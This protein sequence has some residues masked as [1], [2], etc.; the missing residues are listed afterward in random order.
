MEALNINDRKLAKTF[1]YAFIYGASPTKLGSI[2]GVSPVQGKILKDQFLRNVPSLGALLSKVEDAASRGYIRGLDGRRL[3]VR[4]AHAA[5]NTL[6][7]G[8]GSIVCKQWSVNMD[9]SIRSEKLKANLVNTVHD[10]LQYESHMDDAERLVEL[11]SLT[12]KEAGRM[13][14]LRLP[15]DA[16]A[17]IG[18]SWADTH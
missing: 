9:R 15:M 3:Y 14:K 10:E 8:G 17:K 6:L 13:L 11:S 5:L 18:M 1:F 4:H 16:E 2:L 12:I 7:Q